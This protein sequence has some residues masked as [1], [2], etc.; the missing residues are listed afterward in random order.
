MKHWLLTRDLQQ[1]VTTNLDLNR[2]TLKAAKAY[3]IAYGVEVKGSTKKRFLKN[4][5]E[6]IEHNEKEVK[7]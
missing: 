5:N 4:L 2:M 6:L 7:A 3:C 1:T